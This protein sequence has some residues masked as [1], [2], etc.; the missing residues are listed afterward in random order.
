MDGDT[1]SRAQAD[2]TKAGVEGGRHF[3]CSLSSA[4]CRMVQ[5]ML[6]ATLPELAEKVHV[7]CAAGDMEQLKS[8]CCDELASKA[9]QHFA[10]LIQHKVEPGLMHVCTRSVTSVTY[11]F[12]YSYTCY[13]Y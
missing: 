5:V 11:T 13:F 8:L 9:S 1:R 3:I 10:E 4:R 2:K 7:V 12:T 6:M